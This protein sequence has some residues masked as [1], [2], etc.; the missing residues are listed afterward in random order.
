MAA[1][2][3]PRIPPQMGDGPVLHVFD[4]PVKAGAKIFVGALVALEAGYAVA[5]YEAE[6][7]RARG[8]CLG[9]TYGASSDVVDN[10]NGADGALKVKVRAGVFKFANGGDITIAD[11]GKNAYILDDQTVILDGTGRSLAGEIMQ[12]DD[13]GVWVA[14]G[15]AVS[16]PGPQDPPSG[17][18]GETG[19]DG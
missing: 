17:T 4:L 10:T 6:D 13:D 14:V 5:G 16:G 3:A 12:V 8:I 2:S 18:E 11:T 15:W 19:N 1:L 9:P 7:L